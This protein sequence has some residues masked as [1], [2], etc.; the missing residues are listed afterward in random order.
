MWRWPNFSDLTIFEFIDHCKVTFFS[1]RTCPNFSHFP[2][3]VKHVCFPLISH[4][5][6]TR[7]QHDVDTYM[8]QVL[9]FLLFDRHEYIHQESS[10]L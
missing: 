1:A 10:S 2:R 8:D 6:E 9:N 4:Q 3:Q 7:N 5:R